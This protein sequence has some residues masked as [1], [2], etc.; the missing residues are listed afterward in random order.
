MSAPPPPGL[1]GTCRHSRIVETRR[2]STF[3]LCQRST[4]DPR[5]ARYPDLPV[6]RCVGY[7]ILHARDDGKAR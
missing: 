4:T 3:R 5:F 6:V 7:E 1:C 2:G